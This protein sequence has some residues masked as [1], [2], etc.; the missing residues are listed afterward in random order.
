MERIKKM[1][2][3]ITIDPIN[4]ELLDD[5]EIGLGLNRSEI[6]RMVLTMY[7]N[8]LKQLSGLGLVK[9]VEDKKNYDEE[10]KK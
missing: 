4:M 1:K 9:V 2:V 3:S 7:G 10:N 5:L 8:H 6:I